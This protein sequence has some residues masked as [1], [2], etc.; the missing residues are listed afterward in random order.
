MTVGMRP[1]WSAGTAENQPDTPPTAIGFYPDPV[2]V[3]TGCSAE[4]ALSAI[5]A[6]KPPHEGSVSEGHKV[7]QDDA[8]AKGDSLSRTKVVTRCRKSSRRRIDCGS[9]R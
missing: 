7:I 2:G 1:S 3:A 9:P 6:L 4:H 5:G 8:G